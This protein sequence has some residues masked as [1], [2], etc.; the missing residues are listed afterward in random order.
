MRGNR[1]RGTP[2]LAVDLAQALLRR[3]HDHISETIRPGS[4]GLSLTDVHTMNETEVDISS[5]ED[6]LLWLQEE[7][8]CGWS[9]SD[10]R[11]H[12]ER[13]RSG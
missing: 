2:A 1:V 5:Y 9:E 12:D 11:P 3:H 4:S 13:N 6:A 7:K 10:G 8:I